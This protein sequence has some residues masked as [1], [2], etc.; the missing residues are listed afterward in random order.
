MPGKFAPD[1]VTCVPDRPDVG[2]KVEIDGLIVNDPLLVP[3]APLTVTLMVLGPGDADLDIENVS[4]VVVAAVGVTETLPTLIEF[5][6]KVVLNPVPVTVTT[7]L[8]GPDV[9]EKLVTVGAAIATCV[10]SASRHRE[11]KAAD[12]RPRRPR[13]RIVS[14]KTSVDFVARTQTRIVVERRFVLH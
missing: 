13:N 1:T 12:R 10:A 8:A 7:V 11:L 6:P 9:G 2:V 3:V 5:E 14:P 4:C